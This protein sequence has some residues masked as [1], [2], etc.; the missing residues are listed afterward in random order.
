M[1]SFEYSVE[2]GSPQRTWL[3]QELASV[4]R[5]KFPWLVVYSHRPVYCSQ[6]SPSDL[7][8]GRFLRTQVGALLQQYSVDLFFAGHYHAYQRTAP[9]FNNATMLNPDGTVDA[10]THITVGT[11]GIETHTKPFLPATWS[12]SALNSVFGFVQVTIMNSTDA[13]VRMLSVNTTQPDV[14]DQVHITSQHSFT[15]PVAF[16]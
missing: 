11:A 10:T 12:R 6:L 7:K 4:D 15:P 1:I 3:E 9:V 13:I 16:V 8:Y 5:S 2:A 14:V